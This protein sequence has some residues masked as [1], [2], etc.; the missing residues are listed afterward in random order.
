MAGGRVG[1]RTAR[2][3]QSREKGEQQEAGEGQGGSWKEKSERASERVSGEREREQREREQSG[4][5]EQGHRG[6]QRERGLG[7]ERGEKTFSGLGTTRVT[8]MKLKTHTA[9]P[10]VHT[11]DF[12]LVFGNAIRHG[13][14][15]QAEPFS[16]L[17]FPP[18]LA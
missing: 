15:P 5:D 13:L 14:A 6:E 12:F 1:G 17:H 7:G 11:P 3:N 4:V 10:F 8:K 2:F 9:C 16:I 18:L